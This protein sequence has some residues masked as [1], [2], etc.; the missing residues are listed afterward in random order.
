MSIFLP[1]ASTKTEH[2]VLLFRGFADV[3]TG[4]L[5]PMIGT[6]VEVAEPSIV[7]FTVRNLS[8][9]IYD[10]KRFTLYNE[11]KSGKILK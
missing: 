4:Q 3:Q 8:S 2:L 1:A 10:Y 7:T 5:Q 11:R 6:P 9:R